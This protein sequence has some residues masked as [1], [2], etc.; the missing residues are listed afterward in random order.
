[1]SKYGRL[2]AF[3]LLIVVSGVLVGVTMGFLLFH[4]PPSQGGSPMPFATR[5]GAAPTIPSRSTF[6]LPP[7]PSPSL[8]LPSP[9]T[10]PSPW[11]SPT[12]LPTITATPWPLGSPVVI[13]YS[14]EGRAIK[15]YR[16]G[17]G[18]DHRLIIG[19]I[20][21]GYEYNTVMLTQEFVHYLLTYPSTV[22]KEVSL[23]ILPVLNVDGYVDYKG[24]SYGRANAHGVDLNRNFDARWAKTWDKTH[25]WHYQPITAGPHPFSEPETIALREFLNRPDI[26]VTALISYHSSGAVVYAG[27]R[28]SPPLSSVELAKFVAEKTGYRFPSE[29]QCEYT[30]QL[31]DWAAKRGI[32]A[33]DVEL[34]THKDIDFENQWKL[35]YDFLR[36]VPS[37]KRTATPPKGS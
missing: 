22:P 37:A 26:R 5:P 7:F 9:T 1:M 19:G 35:L 17:N 21:G 23:F 27:G 20:H 8:P 29:D 2:F 16:F 4:S 15:V 3:S 32:A 11:P 31:I 13:G 34:P 18:P 12:V 10:T 33:V 36:W 24:L 25:C 30:G 6:T 28:P 14:V